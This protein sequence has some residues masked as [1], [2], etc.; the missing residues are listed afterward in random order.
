MANA[1]KLEIIIGA[2]TDQLKAA[3]ADLNQSLNAVTKQASDAGTQ[4]A[5]SFKGADA[6]FGKTR[7]GVQ[8][9]SEQLSLAKAQLIGFF[10]I[11]YGVGL[12]KDLIQTA[13][14]F[15]SMNARLKLATQS[16]EEY[17]TAQK[18][19]F[20]VSQRTATSIESNIVL[21]ARIAD[22]MR[23]MGKSQQDALAFTELTGQAMRISGASAESAKAGV[24]QLA[25]A[26]ASGVLR[27][28]EFNSVME[29]SPRLAKALAD[30]LGQP[31][32]A[33]RAM[34]EAGEL[35]AD[36]VTDA[37][38]SQT[39][40]LAA[41]YA[42]IPLTVGAALTQISNAWTQF[43]GEADQAEGATKSL[44][45][46]LSDIAKNFSEYANIVLTV[47]RDALVVVA[48]FGAIRLGA[49]VAEFAALIGATKAS[50]AAMAE[51]A[52]ADTQAAAAAVALVNAEKAAATQAVIS[53]QA[54]KATAVAAMAEAEATL[55][56]AS[57]AAL[58]GPARA[59]A[60][61]AVTAARAG[62]TTATAALS[63]AETANAAAIARSAAASSAAA[64]AVT[65]LALATGLLTKA[66][67]PL[68]LAFLAFE[69]L[70]VAG[71]W[72]GEFAAKLVVGDQEVKKFSSGT[73]LGMEVA[74]AA[75]A[76]MKLET[77][78]LV[79]E[80][81]R[82]N[83]LNAFNQVGESADVARIK[84]ETAAVGMIAAFNGIYVKSQD[85]AKALDALLNGVDFK[86]PAGIEAMQRALE[87]LAQTGYATGKQIDEGLG[88]ALDKLSSED[89]RLFQ[90]TAEAAFGGA[91][92]SAAKL[93]SIL[94]AS[95]GSAFRRLGGDLEKFRTGIDQATKEAI[96]AFQAIAENA[97][98]SGKEIGEAFNLALKTADTRQE[99]DALAQALK[100]AA[101]EGVIAG[102][103]LED[104]Q[105]RLQ[106]KINETAGIID[107]PL[108]DAFKR[109]GIKSKAELK[110][111][112]D[113]AK[114]DFEAIKKS[115]T[116]TAEG[117]AT[118][119]GK[120]KSAEAAALGVKKAA[121][122]IAEETNNAAQEAEI[123]GDEMSTAATSIKDAGSG[124][125][126][127]AAFIND[128]MNAA[129]QLYT[130]LGL[131][132]AAIDDIF[133]RSIDKTMDWNWA[134]KNAVDIYEVAVAA[135]ERQKAEISNAAAAT[136]RLGAYA[137]D[138]TRNFNA[139]VQAANDLALG[140]HNAASAGA[141]M[142]AGS[143]DPKVNAEL[144]QQWA[145]AEKLADAYRSIERS[146]RSAA[147]SAEDAVRGFVS[148]S[149]SIHE[150]LLTAQG[151]EDEAAA[152][153]FASRR[154]DLEMSYKQLQV[155]IMIAEVQAKAA[156]IDTSDLS[157]AKS[158]ADAAY[159]QAKND[160]VQ[161]E[162]I[163]AERRRKAK[164]D[165]ANDAREA[166]AK[167]AADKA[168][169][170][171]AAR[172]QLTNQV[173]PPPDNSAYGAA[174]AA[175]GALANDGQRA[176]NTTSNTININVDGSDLLSEEQIRRKIVP[177]I[178]DIINKSR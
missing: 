1:P 18:A 110:A 113:Q 21:Y 49:A 156:G 163:D 43:I 36:K 138:V 118:A 146:A 171:A 101:A 78:K 121:A 22:S 137:D 64:P 54:H 31:I 45:L 33:L 88:R 160:L 62:L 27:G 16:S 149:R 131:S 8:S 150:E 128:Y 66:M 9:I 129:K 65:R 159:N 60:E 175:T 130:Q 53:A 73:K 157:R 120:Y 166:A 152:S 35:T 41:E 58:Y 167:A 108:A 111:L 114:A 86:S 12:A 162:K 147:K 14:A 143:T 112:A 117:I 109:M 51:K 176:G 174:Q 90:I 93:A 5:G 59:A 61:R 50:S 116:A 139:T 144:Q 25:Q 169:S 119:E 42:K 80:I 55:A 123:L 96:G 154:A 124:A 102:K 46:A 145:A 94:D 29:N 52:I 141:S 82:S 10:S 115:G 19:L 151:K 103:D 153:R 37:L 161:L 17:A 164:Q 48:G 125:G 168:A 87:V 105:T 44:A 172:Q 4:T 84:V 26:M 40:T 20:D 148:S 81:E 71:Q 155:Q 77:A 15:T 6:Q 69:G 39:A 99:V 38:L 79:A 142:Q 85:V 74:A 83:K 7:A 24:T 70:K 126:S 11:Q 32:G 178:N 13:D 28:D 72:L 140:M 177:V 57:A 134:I 3:L 68:L 2:K 92:E 170:D 30:G 75:T 23:A 34:A 132:K 47:G 104:A 107:G 136:Q 91:A 133:L 67:G 89:L 76:E 95:L 97:R 98:A 173:K 158:E 127:M 63:A 165:A 106:A 135:V 100:N 122:G 56:A